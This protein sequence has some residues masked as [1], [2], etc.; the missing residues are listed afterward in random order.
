M[1]D[2]V[3]ERGNIIL[4]IREYQALPKYDL[5]ILLLDENLA[6]PYKNVQNDHKLQ[7]KFRYYCWH[8][9]TGIKHQ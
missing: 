9:W 8:H 3:K 2:Y 1:P 5:L 6:I 4:Y 7:F